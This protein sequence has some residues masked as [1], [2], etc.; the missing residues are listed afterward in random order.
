MSIPINDTS[1]SDIP[2]MPYWSEPRW[3]EN[4]LPQVPFKQND[5]GGNLIVNVSFW[6]FK[7]VESQLVRARVPEDL[8]IPDRWEP[9]FGDDAMLEKARSMLGING[10]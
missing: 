4:A 10:T 8:S 5:S 1:T 7:I 6:F 9:V 2:T 3:L